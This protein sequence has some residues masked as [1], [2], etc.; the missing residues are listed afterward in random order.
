MRC[1]PVQQL[2]EDYARGQL[3]PATMARVEEHLAGCPVCREQFDLNDKV[4]ALMRE[5]N[6]VAHPGADYF[7]RLADRVMA[8]LDDEGDALT[9]PPVPDT[10]GRRPFWLQPRW[11]TGMAAAAALIALGVVGEPLTSV[12]AG[13]RTAAAPP[14][15]PVPAESPRTVAGIPPAPAATTAAPAATQSP[16]VE[17]VAAEVAPG[18]PTVVV[19]ADARKRELVIG[20]GMQP[21][22]LSPESMAEVAA[23]PAS[24][25]ADAERSVG[26]AIQPVALRKA[27]EPADTLSSELADQLEAVRQQMAEDGDAALR[28]GLRDLV[29]KIDERTATDATLDTLPGVRQ[30]RLFAEAQDALTEGLP[31]DAWTR[32]RRIL[33]IEPDTPL[34]HRAR[35]Q[36]ADLYYN[37]WADFPAAR[38]YYQ[39]C[40]GAGADKAFTEIELDHIARQTERLRAHAD[41][42]WEALGLVHAVRH[43][44]WP[45]AEAALRRLTSL[46]GAENLLPEAARTVVDRMQNSTATVPM[47]TAIAIYKLLESR[48]AA[49]SSQGLRAWLELALGDMQLVQFQELQAAIDHYNRAIAA[50]GDSGAGRLAATKRDQLIDRQ[51]LELVR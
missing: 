10:L 25:A 1:K 14:P 20:P 23:L 13:R 30:I 17:T 22:R 8:R 24:T 50:G 51:L 38:R 34:A 2:Y 16:P 7:D 15:A 19:S 37:E 6:E 4:A 46:S 18:G 11:W 21:S 28:E 44:E 49:E 26:E 31:R 5:G 39:E 41:N 36:L 32:Y 9:A 33:M 35:L 43:G 42:N 47:E 40:R 45:E 29:H 27:A 3:P 48:S 12:G